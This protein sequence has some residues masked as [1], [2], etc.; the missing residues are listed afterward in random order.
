[1]GVETAGAAV[2]DG[3]LTRVLDNSGDA[4]GTITG[5][6][7]DTEAE[8]INPTRA[9]AEDGRYDVY[10]R[11]FRLITTEVNTWTVASFAVDLIQ[12]GF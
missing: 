12:S 5:V 9:A 11:R 10:P 8:F 1:M 7:V 3:A 2:A 6:A 4:W